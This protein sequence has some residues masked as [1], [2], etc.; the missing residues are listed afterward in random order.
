MNLFPN[1][2]SVSEPNLINKMTAPVPEHK[3]QGRERKKH[4]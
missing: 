3:N 2:K 1:Q 4:K